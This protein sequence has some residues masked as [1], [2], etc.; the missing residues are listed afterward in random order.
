[1]TNTVVRAGK[2]VLA[3]DTAQGAIGAVA[4]K[5]EETTVDKTDDVAGIVKEKPAKAGGRRPSTRTTRKV[6][7][8]RQVPAGTRPGR[9]V[10]GRPVLGRQAP[11]W[12]PGS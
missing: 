12:V 10:P 3:T 1:V 6:V 5:M 7:P 4:D 11:G 9:P 8:G 2:K